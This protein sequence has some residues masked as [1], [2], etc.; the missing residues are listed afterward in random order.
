MGKTICGTVWERFKRMFLLLSAGNDAV[1]ISVQHAWCRC[2]LCG[3]PSSFMAEIVYSRVWGFHEATGCKSSGRFSKFKH[4]LT[5]RM[6]A[7][8]DVLIECLSLDANSDFDNSIVTCDKTCALF[9]LLITPFCFVLFI[10]YFILCVCSHS[11][12]GLL[13]Y[14]SCMTWCVCLLVNS[15]VNLMTQWATVSH[16]HWCVMVAFGLLA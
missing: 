2:T 13:Y 6:R 8:L 5:R 4:R 9:L 7:S 10:Q 1:L 16:V 14:S 11:V 12:L 15:G 3:V